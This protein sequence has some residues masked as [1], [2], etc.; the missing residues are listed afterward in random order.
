M[1]YA[2]MVDSDTTTG[3]ATEIVSS[4]A[5]AANTPSVAH[6]AVP[7]FIPRD[8]LYYWSSAWQESQRRSRAQLAAGEFVEFD[9]PRTMVRWLL[10]E[11]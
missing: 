7:A 8:E 1:T 5:A 4:A 2:V 11:D 3:S 6:R 10:S 9:D